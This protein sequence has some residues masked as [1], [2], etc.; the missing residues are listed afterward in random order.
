[1]NSLEHQI[2]QLLPQT[3]GRQP[4]HRNPQLVVEKRQVLHRT[5]SDSVLFGDFK[6]ENLITRNKIKISLFPSNLKIL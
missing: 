6:S 5:R 4:F 1:L 3:L 2:S